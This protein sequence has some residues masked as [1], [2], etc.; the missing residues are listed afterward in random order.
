MYSI[1]T[2]C[3]LCL[4]PKALALTAAK[5]NVTPANP[6][7]PCFLFPI[8]YY[9]QLL[10]NTVFLYMY[11]SSIARLSHKPSWAGSINIPA[12]DIKIIDR[13]GWVIASSIGASVTTSCHI[14]ISPALAIN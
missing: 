14:Y 12:G 4:V 6:L 3:N 2:V 9:K 11:F 13:V 1:Y 7:L 8:S 10:V 5:K